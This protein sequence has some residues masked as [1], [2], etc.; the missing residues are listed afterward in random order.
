M[1]SKIPTKASSSLLL[2][3]SQK[4]TKNT[5]WF[6]LRMVIPSH[7][8]EPVAHTFCWETSCPLHE[9]NAFL[10][11]DALQDVAQPAFPGASPGTA[12][13]RRLASAQIKHSKSSHTNN[14]TL[15]NKMSTFVFT[16]SVI[17]LWSGNL[18]LKWE[19]P[20]FLIPGFTA[21]WLKLKH[22]NMNRW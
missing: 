7:Q 20:S 14:N 3:P 12:C 6:T 16:S 15:Y 11:E 18:W 21:A 4:D 9:R 22:R 17:L 19:D 1:P 13:W 2:L 8:L 10:E 5:S